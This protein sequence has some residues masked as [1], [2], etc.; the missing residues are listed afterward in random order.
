MNYCLAIAACRQNPNMT[1][2]CNELNIHL[3]HK[4]KDPG[5]S[6]ICATKSC[7]VKACKQL[8]DFPFHV[9]TFILFRLIIY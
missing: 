3:A 2:A 5:M 9:Q 4:M 7:Q 8:G 1:P 6:K